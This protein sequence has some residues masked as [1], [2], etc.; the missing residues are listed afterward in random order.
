MT[1]MKRPIR[2][3]GGGGFDP[4]PLSSSARP[5]GASAR[6]CLLYHKVARRAFNSRLTSKE[7]GD[8]DASWLV[9]TVGTLPRFPEMGVDAFGSPIRPR[10]ME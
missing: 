5:K 9:D 2:S 8:A 7:S 3:C 4:G 6:G 1:A 10:I